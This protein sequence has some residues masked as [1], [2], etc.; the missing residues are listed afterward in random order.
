MSSRDLNSHFARMWRTPVRH[1][2]VALGLAGTIMNASAW[3]PVGQPSDDVYFLS[4]DLRVDFSPIFLEV[5]D[6]TRTQLSPSSSS[7]QIDTTK[8]ENGYYQN[9]SVQTMLT[10]TQWRDA[11]LTLVSVQSDG[12]WQLSTPATKGVSIGGTLTFNDLTLDLQTQQI[13][14]S[15]T[16]ANGY[17]TDSAAPL[18]LASS[19]RV[20]L[21]QQAPWDLSSNMYDYQLTMSGLSLTEA[22]RDALRQS[23]GLLTLGKTALDAVDDVGTA[24]VT[25]KINAPSGFALAVVPEPN[26]SMLMGLG[27]LAIVAACR[28]VAKRPLLA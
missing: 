3:T 20:E 23:L 8:D 28:R 2:L 24:R 27:L 17:L 1:C 11:P 9:A 13:T 4:G 6:A 10:A 12:A 14:A 25:I 7:I 21:L 5:L 15:L 22:G 18:W 26:T 19:V 16:G